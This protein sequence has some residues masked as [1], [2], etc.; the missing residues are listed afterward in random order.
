M[1]AHDQVCLKTL[2]IFS[3]PKVFCSALAE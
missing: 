2:D 1:N 3:V